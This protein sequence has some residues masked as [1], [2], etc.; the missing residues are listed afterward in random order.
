MKIL[1]FLFFFAFNLTQSQEKIEVFFD[2]DNDVPNVTS[3]S[4]FNI[5]MNENPNVEVV[6]ITGHCDATDS[7]SYNK[8]LASRRIKSILENIEGSK[9]KIN[10]NIIIENHGEDFKQSIKQSDNRKVVVYYKKVN[11]PNN[12]YYKVQKSNKGDL[13]KLENI[14]F[15]YSSARLLSKSYK[16]LN[17]LIQVLN[18]YP[19]L[20]IEIQGHVCC[21]LPHQFD[22]VSTDR[23]KAICNF[24]TKNKIS[25]TRL[26]F[27]GYGASR[28]VHPIPEKSI[29]EEDENRRVEILV[30]ER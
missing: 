1:F 22:I 5:W 13:I 21:Q 24:L 23:A 11:Q 7:N 28:P 16:T 20:Q 26:T 30:I 14:Y 6:K 3:T 25:K 8:E 12:L 2:S 9:I 15:D 17:E 29:Q 19:T 27:K 10:S 18:D 4:I